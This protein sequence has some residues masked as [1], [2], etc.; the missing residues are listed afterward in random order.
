MPLLKRLR[1]ALGGAGESSPRSIYSFSV[2][3]LRCQEVITAQVNLQNDLSADYERNL[4]HVRK[5]ISGSGA[6][7]CFQ[8]IE[9]HLTFDMNKNLLDREISGGEFV[10]D[11]DD[12]S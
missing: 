8:S 10:D 9:V 3:C 4:F 7:R 1:D 6:N 12:L 5:L 11:S 2:R